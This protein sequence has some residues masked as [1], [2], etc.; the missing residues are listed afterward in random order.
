MLCYFGYLQ[1]KPAQ[2]PGNGHIQVS[3]HLVPQDPAP[4]PRGRKRGE[5]LGAETLSDSPGGRA[6]HSLISQE[7]ALYLFGGYGGQG[8]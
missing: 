4:K 3:W 8:Q 7:Y 6:A 5:H 1:I 2:L